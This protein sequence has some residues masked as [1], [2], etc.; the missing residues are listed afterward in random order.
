[1]L[2][3][4]RYTIIDEADEMVESDW[5]REMDVIMG[6]ADSNTDSDHVYLLFSATFN[7]DARMLAKKYMSTDHVRVR[8]GRAGSTHANV[9]QKII[10]VEPSKKREALWDLLMNMPPARTIVFTNRKQEVD[11]IDDY[12]WNKGLPTTSIHSDRTQREREDAIRA[13]KIGKA[14]ILITTSVAARGLDLKHTLHI[15]NYDF[16]RN[17]NEYVHRIGRT[18]R[19]GNIG[20]ATT[21]YND[22]DE[23]QAEDLVKLMLESKQ[24]IP[25]FLEHLKPEGAVDFEDNSDEEQTPGGGGDAEGDGGAGNAED[26]GDAGD[27]DGW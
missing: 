13:F 26:A 20:L 5:D 23:G 21:F 12:L 18:A 22:K 15:I 25:D 8:V 2:T 27:A 3:A 4:F 1:M 6:G 10:F 14:P 17:I 11:L 19:I 24:D 7:K 9:V 16:P